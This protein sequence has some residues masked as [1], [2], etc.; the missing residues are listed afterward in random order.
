MVYAVPQPH[1]SGYPK[2]PRLSIPDAPSTV[3]K[4]YPPRPPAGFRT[5]VT[6]TD[7]RSLNPIQVYLF[8]IFFLFAHPEQGWDV[9]FPSEG[10]VT[11]AK[12]DVAVY[13]HN[14]SRSGSYTLRTGDV[15]RG[16]YNGVVAMS[17]GHFQPVAVEMFMFEQSIGT[18]Y[19][20]DRSTS[21]GPP[22]SQMLPHRRNNDRGEEMGM[23]SDPRKISNPRDS[24]RYVDPHAI[25]CSIL[26]KWS[27]GKIQSKDIF[28]A[29]ME[30]LIIIAHDGTRE[31]FDS[32]N[33]PSASGNCA[34]N[35][36][37]VA[38]E[39]IKLSG[40]KASTL[41]FMLTD[42]IVQQRRFEHLDFEFEYGAPGDPEKRILEGFIMGL[43]PPRGQSRDDEAAT[44]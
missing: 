29:I 31:P 27:P 8:A 10:V 9:P 14:P 24:G 5:K 42:M 35:I 15:L 39:P 7:S 11:R 28:T 20:S 17:D 4:G 25:G 1:P 13:V 18:I 30:G 22:S 12:C 37:K 40:F 34:L 2:L 36:R 19:I 32:L 23:P 44:A 26:Y 43:N 38:R 41:L 33:A 16:L 3:S 6:Y 21:H